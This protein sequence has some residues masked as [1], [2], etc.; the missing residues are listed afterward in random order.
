[1]GEYE[2][3]LERAEGGDTA[4]FAELKKFGG[5]DLRR[6]AER[7]ASLEK[8]MEANAP[9]VREGRFR[10]VVSQLPDD[11][12][13][14]DLSLADIGNVEPDQITVDLLTEKAQSKREEANRVRSAVA[15][16][17]GFDSVEDFQAALEATKRGQEAKVSAMEKVGSGAAS[18]GGAPPDDS[19]SSPFEAMKA[20]FDEAKS[21]GMSDDK[22]M[23]EG[24]HG[25][26][27]AQAPVE[28]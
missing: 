25:L 13:D 2:D 4:A 17:A 3:L 28:E 10:E 1:M 14:V 6:Q 11:L 8:Q 26:M 19:P 23:G 18:G 27:A 5:Q 15:A 20:D 12:K 22:A 16:D 24:V 9:F 7:A 21:M